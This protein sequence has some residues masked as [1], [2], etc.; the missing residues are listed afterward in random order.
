MSKPTSDSGEP[1]SVPAFSTRPARR[2][3]EEK[4][5]DSDKA[6]GKQ[7]DSSSSERGQ[8]ERR[9][10]VDGQKVNSAATRATNA[11]RSSRAVALPQGTARPCAT[12]QCTRRDPQIQRTCSATPS[13]PGHPRQRAC[14]FSGLSSPLPRRPPQ[15]A[16]RPHTHQY[17][18]GADHST[19]GGRALG[20]RQ[21]GE[22]CRSSPLA[23]LRAGFTSLRPAAA[24]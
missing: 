13:A 15:V 18:S 24:I 10:R 23:S 16:P 12:L 3:S 1:A 9:T 5:P 4:V 2:Q 22:W 14:T 6:A 17:P 11:T 19:C 20:G 8:S 21:S 7:G